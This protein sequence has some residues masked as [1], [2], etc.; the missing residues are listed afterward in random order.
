M[1]NRK[2]QLI[3]RPLK[4]AF[5][6]ILTSDGPHELT[7]NLAPNYGNPNLVSPTPTDPGQRLHSPFGSN[8]PSPS[9]SPISVDL[10]APTHKRIP[11]QTC[12]KI[13][14]YYR[15]TNEN[16][17]KSVPKTER[18][19]SKIKRIAQLGECVSVKVCLRNKKKFKKIDFNEVEITSSLTKKSL[20]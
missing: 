9:H 1:E 4:P 2:N 6:Y 20:L 15:K 8:G 12:R 18:Q 14:S 7:A 16:Y 19:K 13:D 11:P 17:L 3:K 10:S 5:G